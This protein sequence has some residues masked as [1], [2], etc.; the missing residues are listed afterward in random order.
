MVR[1]SPPSSLHYRWAHQRSLPGMTTYDRTKKAMKATKSVRSTH[2]EPDR[3]T[4]NLGMEKVSFKFVSLSLSSLPHLS[5]PARYASFSDQWI[6]KDLT[7]KFSIGKSH[8]IIGPSGAGKTTIFN[9]LTK[10][11]EPKCVGRSARTHTLSSLLAAILTPAIR[12]E[13]SITLDGQDIATMSHEEVLR[14]VGVVEQ[15]PRVFHRSIWDNITYSKPGA[16]AEEVDEVC[17]QTNC[18]EFISKMPNGYDTIIG[19]GPARALS[20]SPVLTLVPPPD[21]GEV[22]SGGQKQRLVLARALLKNP[23]ILLLD[24][25]TS[26]LD[27]ENAQLITDL[28]ISLAAERTLIFITH[29]LSTCRKADTIFFLQGGQVVE[30]GSHDELMQLHGSYF[31]FI[32]ISFAMAAENEHPEMDKKK[33]R[34]GRLLDLPSQLSDD[35]LVTAQL[36]LAS[37]PRFTQMTSSRACPAPWSPSRRPTSR[38][39]PRMRRHQRSRAG[40]NRAQ[41]RRRPRMRTLRCNIFYQ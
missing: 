19:E 16:T 23:R 15:A 27:V 9:L 30:S 41:R 5:P 36:L 26:E 24:E 20:H 18:S 12:S 8:A 10:L 28:I 1:S 39:I 35:Q 22:I 7:M 29:S 34:E 3:T 31:N 13:G 6:L 14:Y 4:G 21:S 40:G 37:S 2:R 25:P 38:P 11:Y 17:R 32:Q 33:K